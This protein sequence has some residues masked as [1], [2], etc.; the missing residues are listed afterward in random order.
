MENNINFKELA[1]KYGTPYY[2]YDFDHIAS[3]Y[4]ELKN[5]FRERK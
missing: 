2:V 3:Q 5:A 1:T 4:N